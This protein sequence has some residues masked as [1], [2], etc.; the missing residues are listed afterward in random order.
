LGVAGDSGE[1]AIE[2]K[3]AWRQL[4]ATEQAGGRFFMREAI[5]YKGGSGT[6]SGGTQ[7]Y[8]NGIF[9]LVALHIIHKT[10][11]FPAFVFATWEQVDNYDDATHTNSEF[12]GFINTGT[13]LPDPPVA[14][15]HPIHSQV[16]PVNDAVHTLFMQQD[17]NTVWQYYKLVGVQAQPMNSPLLGAPSDDFSYY[18][19][20]NIVVETN[21]T[22]QNFS[23]S[24]SQQTGT[25]IPFKN[26]YLNGAAGSPFQMGGCQGC[27]GTQG[28]VAGGDF[29][30]VVSGALAKSVNPPLGFSNTG[31]DSI[32]TTP[33]GSVASY[34]ARTTATARK[35]FS[36]AKKYCPPNRPQDQNCI[37]PISNPR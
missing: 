23:G 3:A 11:S 12:L 24:V 22:L 36:P 2:I 34:N 29:S 19:L 33:P 32:D 7:Q 10:K 25:P 8:Y 35:Y 1:G 17:P 28:Q 30:A 15:A 27:H 20:A 16:A 13:N 21:Q 6:T 18:Y 26:V 14:R 4:T 5:Y 31:V 37:F 9:G